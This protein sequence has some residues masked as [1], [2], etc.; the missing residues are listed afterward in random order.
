MHKKIT[1]S[2]AK[3]QAIVIYALNYEAHISAIYFLSNSMSN[4]KAL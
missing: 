4:K 2:D 1:N 3:R